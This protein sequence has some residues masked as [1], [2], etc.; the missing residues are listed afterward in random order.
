MRNITKKEI[1]LLKEFSSNIEL[2]LNGCSHTSN[3]S[4]VEQQNIKDG[5]SLQAKESITIINSILSEVI[6]GY[7][8][9]YNFTNGRIRCSVDYNGDKQDRSFYGVAYYN[10]DDLEK[11]NLGDK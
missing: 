11:F 10:I 4:G 8:T 5:L 3:Y 6:G 9:F 7:S 2:N 1:Q